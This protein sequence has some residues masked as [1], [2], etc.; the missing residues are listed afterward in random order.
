[1]KNNLLIDHTKLVKGQKLW[2]VQLG[3][4]KFQSN[5]GLDSTYPL[6]IETSQGRQYYTI[7]GKH[8]SNHK[9][10]SLYQSNPFEQINEFPKLMEIEGG[11]TQYYPR[12][13]MAKTKKGYWAV[14][15]H[16][17]LNILE[18]S[19]DLTIL[20]YNFN[21]VREIQEPQL[22]ELSIEEIAKRFEI[23]PKL[24]RIKK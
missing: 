1:M 12:I 18:H 19:K 11:D 17:N 7:E 6:I 4:V 10:P 13:I 16:T 24:L 15:S 20:F 22:I 14:E 9:L 2:H 21:E 3:E 8:I 23:D 5:N